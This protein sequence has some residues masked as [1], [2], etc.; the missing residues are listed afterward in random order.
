MPTVTPA[1]RSCYQDPRL[2]NNRKSVAQC[3]TARAIRDA[4]P[5]PA[6]IIERYRPR[7]SAGVLGSVPGALELFARI[8]EGVDEERAGDREQLGE[9]SGARVSSDDR[10]AFATRTLAYD[11][12]TPE[13]CDGRRRCDARRSRC[14]RAGDRA[15]RLDEEVESSA[16]MRRRCASPLKSI[17]LIP[18]SGSLD[19]GEHRFPSA[20]SMNWMKSSYRGSRVGFGY[21]CSG[22]SGSS[23][24]FEVAQRRSRRSGAFGPPGL[25]LRADRGAER[26]DERHRVHVL[27]GLLMPFRSRRS[28]LIAIISVLA[29]TLT[30]ALLR[31]EPGSGPS[32][33][34]ITCSSSRRRPR[35]PLVD[36]APS[37][38]PA[39]DSSRRVLGERGR[40]HRRPTAGGRLNAATT[41]TLLPRQPARRPVP[42]RDRRTASTGRAPARSRPRH[43][44]VARRRDPGARP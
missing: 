20:D 18:Y 22:S 4:R 7:R 31:L 42:L 13:H 23:R 35:A 28:R 38:R 24:A 32:K 33:I 2:P 44:P 8:R 21:S 36:A 11:T 5:S 40:R 19:G 25:S 1:S 14:R 16:R 12:V 39:G 37:P 10:R 29:L 34:S 17:R 41:S 27:R 6:S 30:A 15:V 3:R 26:H 43:R 9:S